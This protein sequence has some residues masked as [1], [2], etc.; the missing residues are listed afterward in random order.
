MAD[1]KVYLK[2]GENVLPVEPEKGYTLSLQDSD[3][4]NKTEGGTTVRD[5]VRMNIPFISVSFDCDKEMLLEMRSYKA[6]PSLDV[7]YFDPA[8]SNELQKD[9]MYVTNYSEKMLADTEDGG[10]WRVTFDL[11]DLGNV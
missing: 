9:S 3:S 11:E 10:I 1:E 2:I 5:I 8:E 7:E 4:T 6:E